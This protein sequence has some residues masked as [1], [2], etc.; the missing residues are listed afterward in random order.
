MKILIQRVK[1]A[2]VEINKNTVGEISHGLLLYVCF[3]EQDHLDVIDQAVKKITNLRI[4][5]DEDNKMNYNILQSQGE[6]LSISQFTL[7]WDGRKGYRPSFDRSMPPNDAKLF[8][9]KFNDAIA[10]QGIKL[11]K[12]RFGAEMDVYSINDG[13]VTFFLSF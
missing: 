13:P 11:A 8:Y 1:E 6:I 3:E 12:G 2:R 4:F 10:K 7:S 5:E 9:R